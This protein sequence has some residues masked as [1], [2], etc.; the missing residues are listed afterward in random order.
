MNSSAVSAG[1]PS[2]GMVQEVPGSHG[3]FFKELWMRLKECH[4]DEVQGLQIKINK[5]KKERCLDAQRLE[6]FYSKN[7]QLREHQ[8][9]LQENVKVLEDRLRA[10]LCDRC[11]VTEEHM[12]KKQVEFEKVRQQNLRLITE[13]MNE[14]NSLQDENKK[15]SQELKHLQSSAAQKSQVKSPEPEEGVIPDSPM[16]PASLPI[17]NKMRR[18]KDGRH[19]R[20]AEN[21]GSM[22]QRSIPVEEHEK[23]VHTDTTY[24]HDNSVLVPETCDMDEALLTKRYRKFAGPAVAVVAET[25]RLDVLEEEESKSVHDPFR[26]SG[27]MEGGA[28]S[29]ETGSVKTNESSSRHFSTS[30]DSSSNK[31]CSQHQKTSPNSLK[32]LKLQESRINGLPS[33]LQDLNSA[34]LERLWAEVLPHTAPVRTGPLSRSS[35]RTSEKLQESV[36][37]DQPASR[38]DFHC[39]NR[40]DFKNSI[41]NDLADK[42]LDLSDR[43]PGVSVT[44]KEMP[45]HKM[46]QASMLEKGQERSSLSELKVYNGGDSSQGQEDPKQK[47]GSHRSPKQNKHLP[48]FKLPSSPPRFKTTIHQL[49]EVMVKEIQEPVRK[50]C[51][52]KKG[53]ETAVVLQSSFCPQKNSPPHEPDDKLSFMADQTWSLDPGANLSQYMTSCPPQTKQDPPGCEGETVDSD[54]TFVSHSM[55]LKSPKHNSD[56]TC[57]GLEEKPRDSFTEMFD[58]TAY[59]EY[60]SC[61]QEEVPE[62]EPKEQSHEPEEEVEQSADETNEKLPIP[63]NE[64]VVKPHLN[65]CNRTKGSFPHVEVV[66]KKEERRKLKGHTCKEC[67]IYY[68]GLPEEERLKKLSA[69]SRHRFRYI[70][71][72]TPEHFWE[73]GFPSTQT[74][75][76]R[77]YIKEDDEPHLRVRRRRPYN[78]VFSP[79]GKEQKTKT[80][81]S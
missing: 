31:E 64:V 63:P 27:P 70:P 10:G 15:L 35:S 6:E 50:K 14:K 1:S 43:L 48:S 78:A 18:R 55:L 40:K 79:K 34:T 28:N 67:E 33:V 44:E 77:G 46:K 71:P 66:R 2:S 81:D 37:Q 58:R 47:D 53:S 9:V 69:C 45:K 23:G 59:G 12:K 75:V 52:T 32:L 76:E 80:S 65:H 51:R 61:P 29:Q 56:S 57:L 68:A 11:A 8:K 41:A 13:L 54:C 17:V 25:C 3:E 5:L 16:R 49:F 38:H 39:K 60:E 20:Y 42:P 62:M 7:Q 72:S 19:V 30:P 22:S 36:G 74:C 73:V 4:D 24:G 26:T 21:P